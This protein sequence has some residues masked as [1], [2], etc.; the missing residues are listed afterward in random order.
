MVFLE[1]DLH[2]DDDDDIVPSELWAFPSPCS[3]A[4]GNTLLVLNFFM[5]FP[6]QLIKKKN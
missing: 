2:S 3:L 4:W 1:L 5:V 6:A